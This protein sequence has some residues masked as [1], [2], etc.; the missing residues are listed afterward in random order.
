MNDDDCG[1]TDGS[2]SSETRPG[3][4]S[5]TRM[6]RRA[7]VKTAAAGGASLAFGAVPVAGPFVRRQGDHFVPADKKLSADWVDALFARGTAAWYDGGDLETIGMPVGGIAA[8]QVYLTGDGRL[9]NWDIF[10]QNRNTGAGAVNYRVGRP[11]EE[12]VTG[13]RLAPAPEVGQ[14][15][16]IRVTS[17]DRTFERTLDQDGFPA[18]RFNG[19]YPIARV[20]Y[21]D[22]ASPVT[23]HLEAF[24]PFIPLESEDSALPATVLRFTVRNTS[25][26]AADVTLAGWLDNG[27]CLHSGASFA[28]RFAR[29]NAPLHTAALTGV[30]S[31]ARI[32]ELPARVE[33]DPI[34]FADFEGNDY[35]AWTVAGEAFGT[36]SGARDAA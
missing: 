28:D 24:S 5:L 2:C 27:V 3:L 10:N 8:G 17:S 11:P 26:R 22:P 30:L 33:R 21:W 7:F 23:V 15:F 19:E 4:T 32:L 35:G 31:S 29:R 13:G 14:G 20:E 1:C 34:V 25:A 36:A 12:T 6:D 9:V 18:V 16:A